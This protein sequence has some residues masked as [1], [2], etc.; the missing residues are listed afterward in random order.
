MDQAGVLSVLKDC[1]PDNRK[2]IT[3]RIKLPKCSSTHQRC[4]ICTCFLYYY[5]CYVNH[6]KITVVCSIFER[7]ECKG[8]ANFYILQT[9]LRFF[10]KKHHFFFFFYKKPTFPAVI[11]DVNA[12][13]CTFF[14]LFTGLH[15]LSLKK[16]V[17][18]KFW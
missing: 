14:T 6:S 18:E 5:F 3:V 13:F 8:T 2:E 4:A 15:T 12:T 7:S 16:V 9:F 10:F 17:E 11:S 1:Y